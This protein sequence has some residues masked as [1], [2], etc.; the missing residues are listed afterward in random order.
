MTDT[1]LVHSSDLHIGGE[2]RA[3]AHSG[4]RGLSGVLE[5]AQATGAHLVMLAG[6][7]FDNHRVA[8]TTLRRTAELIGSVDMPVVIL[9]GNHDPLLGNCLFRRSGLSELPNV[10]VLGLTAPESIVFARLG[11]EIWG[12]AHRDY[13]DM[14]PLRSPRPR[15]TV[16]QVVMA[17]GHY[18]P[19]DDWVA[20]AHRSWKISDDD[21]AAVPA[22]YIALGHWD[23]AVQVGFGAA[24]AYYSGSP[25]LAATVNL[26]R[27]SAASGVTVERTPVIWTA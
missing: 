17:H 7:T 26:V 19:A 3:E 6:D 23:R 18:V 9:P 5:T 22:D 10:S 14:A 20:E 21:L 12:W 11:L 4:L 2:F 27:L 25:D 8:E 13:G 1:K 16:W 15:T 24:P